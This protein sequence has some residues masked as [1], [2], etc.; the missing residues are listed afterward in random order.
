MKKQCKIY[1]KC[2]RLNIFKTMEGC[3]LKE[4]LL[5]NGFKLSDVA[6]GLNMSQQAL[7]N[8]LNVK[9]LKIDFVKKVE[10]LTG[11][12][13]MNENKKTSTTSEVESFLNLLKKKDEQMDRLITLLEQAYGQENKK[14]KNV[15]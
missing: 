9:N 3:R 10:A 12:N 2:I 13:I 14:K 5:E 11:L 4:I 6:L 15:G 8:R 1:E 7:S